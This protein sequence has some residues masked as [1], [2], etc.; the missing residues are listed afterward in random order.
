MHSVPKCEKTETLK[1][2]G[3]NSETVC[4]TLGEENHPKQE[5]NCTRHKGET[6]TYNIIKMENYVHHKKTHTLSK[7]STTGKIMHLKV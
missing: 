6:G 7:H 3:E 5:A 1:L 4:T 2:L